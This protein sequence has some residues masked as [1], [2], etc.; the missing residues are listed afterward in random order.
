MS[1]PSPS[2]FRMWV[3]TV[4]SVACLLVSPSL[5]GIKDIS[6]HFSDPTPNP[7]TFNGGSVDLEAIPLEFHKEN[8]VTNDLIFDGFEDEDYIDFDAILAAGNDDYMWVLTL[9]KILKKEVKV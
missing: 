8:T 4:I 2:A 5:A 3:I 6:S 1:I 7:R 9:K